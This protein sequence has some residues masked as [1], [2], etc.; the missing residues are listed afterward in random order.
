ME[1]SL[2]MRKKATLFLFLGENFLLKHECTALIPEIYHILLLKHESTAIIP[3]MLSC[4]LRYQD[5]GLALPVSQ[6]L[7]FHRFAVIHAP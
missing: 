5:P 3:Q 1:T 6:E 2:A 7:R 4:T